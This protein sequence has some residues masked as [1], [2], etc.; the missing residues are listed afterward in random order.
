MMFF[1][2]YSFSVSGEPI[3]SFRLDHLSIEDGLPHSS[4]SKILQ[5]SNGYMWFGTQSGLCRYDGYSFKTYFNDPFDLNSL[6]HNLIQTMFLDRDNILWL[7]TY[8]GLSKLNIRD[9]SFTN[10]LNISGDENS[11]SNNIIVAIERDNQG[12]LW[13]GTLDGLNL[14]NEKTGQFIRYV[15][16]P[17]NPSSLPDN[18]VR[19]I[20]NDNDGNLWIGTYGGL[21]LWNDQSQTFTN[22]GPKEGDIHSLPNKYVMDI[23]TSETSDTEIFLGLWGGGVVR[24]DTKTKKAFRYEIPD[25]HV[26]TILIDDKNRLW[27][28]TWGGGLTVL[29]IEDGSLTHFKHETAPDL[30]HNIIYSLFQDVSGVVWI[31]TNGGGIN[32]YVDWKNQYNVYTHNPKDPLSIPAGKI[33]VAY[34]DSKSRLW[35]GFQG[36]GLSRLDRSNGIFKNY[37]HDK[38]DDSSISNSIVNAIYEDL[39]GNLLIGTNHGLNRYIESTD[40]FECSY[41]GINHESLAENLIYSIV[42]DDNDNLWLGSYTRGITVLKNQTGELTYYRND[43]DDPNSLSDNLIRSIFIDSENQIWICTNNGL[44]LF[45]S[46]TETFKHFYHD[47]NDR[48]SISSN[49]VRRM[50][51]DSEGNLWIATN[52]GGVNLYNRA[53]DSFTLIST[54]DGLLSNSVI[55]IEEDKGGNLLFLTQSGISLYNR[56]EKLF[57][58]I[59]A[60]NGLLSSEL[61][62]GYVHTEDGSFYIGSNNGITEIPLFKNRDDFFTPTVLIKGFSILGIP[63]GENRTP[64]WD[65]ESIPL[66]HFQNTISFEFTLNDY[67]T[68]GQ[69]QF[70]YKLEGVDSKWVYSGDRNYARYT[71]LK[72]GEY[73]FRVIGADSRNNWNYGGDSLIIEI[74]T[75]FWKSHFAY[76]LYLLFFVLL[77]LAGILRIKRLEKNANKKIDEQKSLNIELEKRVVERTAE[78]EEARK[79][80]EKAT[81]TKS[82]FLANMSHELRTPLNAVIGFSALLNE[83]DLNP[84][85]KHIISSI[86]NAGKNLSILINDL[87]DFSKIEAGEMSIKYTPVNISIVLFEIKHIF[88]LRIKEKNL[89]FLLEI[90]PHIPERL[91]LDE[92][93]FRQILINLI[94][95]S[96]KFTNS[97]F[98]K[99]KLKN[100]GYKEQSHSITLELTVKDSGIGISQKEKDKIFNLFWQSEDAFKNKPNGTG[101]GLSITENFVKLMNGDISIESNINEGST[102]KI[103]FHDVNI[104]ENLRDHSESIES[105]LL[106]NISFKGIRALI[107]DD[108]N[109][110][111]NLLKEIMDQIKIDTDDAA[112]GRDAIEL[113]ESFNP[114]IIFMDVQMPVMDGIA[115]SMKIK[116]NPVTRHIPIVAVTASILGD[117]YDRENKKVNYFS[118][119]I[120]KP[121]SMK[122]ITEVLKKLLSVDTFSIKSGSINIKDFYGNEKIIN[123]DVLMKELQILEEQW[124]GLKPTGRMSILENF[125]KNLEDIGKRY[126][127]YVLTAYAENFLTSVGLFD[128]PNLE[129]E[130]ARFPK[131]IEKLKHI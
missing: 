82:I 29:S 14:F 50:F 90:D 81:R 53:D 117:F 101:L 56:D 45:E 123:R 86:K 124:R 5:D 62:S 57:T 100:L 12:R 25:M 4:I 121:Y 26:Y 99:V 126:N 130:L 114:D 28:G 83:D 34:E 76:V 3:K 55:G 19:S 15:H 104:P 80:A 67:S 22:W 112:N 37:S 72:P 131:I 39:E 107:V 64:L 16:D 38:N 75:P 23:T 89:S 102:F 78:I 109:N 42:E 44:N 24:F 128:L 2:V 60:K 63:Y 47:I 65:L 9:N 113:A 71:Q 52:G 127:A 93:R 120:S 36:S 70:A 88:S 21:S 54:L 79:V 85:K 49:D 43:K 116:S 115:A 96:V 66:R 91:M 11:L 84:E 32:K 95:N 61:T 48:K 98:I 105:D 8:N 110:N 10:Y 13:I 1:A 106:E 41:M 94:G 87:L 51:E 129:I 92:T 30:S 46:E 27:A 77:L 35:F 40:S 59:N 108:N 18:T 111:R 33:M 17:E 97:G 73:T 31:G 6:P 69:N 74:S 119:Y 122:N 103:T 7:G 118:A 68:E 58:I 125:G 20:L